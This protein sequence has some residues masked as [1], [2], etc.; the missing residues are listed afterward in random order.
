MKMAGL[1]FMAF[2]TLAPLTSHA[3]FAK[4]D[5]A[6]WILNKTSKKIVFHSNTYC[7]DGYGTFEVAAGKSTIVWWSGVHSGSCFFD[8]KRAFI[9]A[10]G[11][12]KRFQV[13]ASAGRDGNTNGQWEFLVDFDRNYGSITGYDVKEKDVIVQLTFVK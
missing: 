1:L 10:E 12:E 3:T 6:L 4:P 5:F 2:A 9:W 11:Y 8:S 13:N 7:S